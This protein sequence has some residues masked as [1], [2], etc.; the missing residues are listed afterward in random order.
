[1]LAADLPIKTIGDIMGHTSTS[2]TYGY[3]KVDLHHLRSASLSIAEVL[4]E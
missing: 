3:M 4:N 1:M 2:S